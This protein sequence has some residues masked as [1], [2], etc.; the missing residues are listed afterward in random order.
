MAISPLSSL[1]K[2]KSE[3]VPPVSTVTLYLDIVRSVYHVIFAPSIVTEAMHCDGSDAICLSSAPASEA[4]IAS[5]LFFYN[6]SDFSM[7]GCRGYTQMADDRR[8]VGCKS[9]TLTVI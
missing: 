5:P 6:E 7:V 4:L 8:K 1:K 9:S 3:N 2:T